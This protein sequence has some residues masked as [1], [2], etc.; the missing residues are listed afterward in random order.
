VST[1]SIAGRLDH[2]EA[3][4]AKE[5]ARHVLHVLPGAHIAAK[6]VLG[7]L[8]PLCHAMLLPRRSGASG[9]GHERRVHAPPSATMFG[10]QV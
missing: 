8:N 9:R 10:L 2:I 3:V 1:C 6:E 4:R 5:V 7:S